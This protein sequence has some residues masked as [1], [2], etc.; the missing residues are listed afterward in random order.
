MLDA[1]NTRSRSARFF[2]WA[3]GGWIV[4]F[5]SPI[6]HLPSSPRAFAASAAA[7]ICSCDSPS[8]WWTSSTTTAPS[9]VA[10]STF[11]RNRVDSDDSSSLSFFS[12]ALS[13]SDSRAPA[14]TNMSS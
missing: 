2:I 8:S 10:A 7:P 4:V 1:R 14:R 12:V 13:A 6:T 9:L 3:S 5:C 11:W